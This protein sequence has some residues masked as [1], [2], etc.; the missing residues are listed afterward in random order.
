MRRS[1]ISSSS[2]FSGAQRSS[3]GN[4]LAC[5]GLLGNPRRGHARGRGGLKYGLSAVPPVRVRH[6]LRFPEP[7]HR[8]PRPRQPVSPCR[9]A[10]PPRHAPDYPRTGWEGL[11]RRDPLRRHIRGRWCVPSC[12]PQGVGRET[13]PARPRSAPRF[14]V[15]AVVRPQCD[16]AGVVRCVGDAHTHQR[17]HPALRAGCRVSLQFTHPLRLHPR[18]SAGDVN[19]H[20][21][22]LDQRRH[23]PHVRCALAGGGLVTLELEGD[24][25]PKRNG[26]HRQHPR[27]VA[28]HRP[29]S[30]F[31]N[32]T[33]VSSP[34]AIYRGIL[35][36]MKPHAGL[37]K[38]RKPS[39]NSTPMVNRKVLSH[40]VVSAIHAFGDA[41]IEA[42]IEHDQRTCSAT[43]S[44][45]PLS[46][47]SPSPPCG[48]P[49]PPSPSRVR[50]TTHASSPR[51]PFS[52]TRSKTPVATAP[53]SSTTAAGRGRMCAG[54]G[55]WIWF[56]GKSE[57]M[58][59]GV[60]ALTRAV[61]YH[62]ARRPCPSRSSCHETLLS[63][64]TTRPRTHVT[65]VMLAA[66]LVCSCSCSSRTSADG[67]VGLRPPTTPE[68]PPGCVRAGVRLP[69]HRSRGRFSSLL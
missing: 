29:S 49:T 56:S 45:Q 8:D 68:C 15:K 18:L 22:P 50:C 1:R 32:G 60:G 13:A 54:A 10:V 62:R 12:G 35:S 63:A 34:P 9:R 67:R 59:K 5:L 64:L 6:K 61:W 65:L 36:P 19:R 42:G 2:S 17:E 51:C 66:V 28:I 37:S 11:R 25:R 47:P 53:T 38:R 58:G 39:L 4:T 69:C 33:C 52:R 27:N 40:A 57:R 21:L 26:L 55:P 31:V 23:A 44:R 20:P 43:S 24:R 16:R 14:A 48:A 46:L 30:K 3:N 41:A 7:C